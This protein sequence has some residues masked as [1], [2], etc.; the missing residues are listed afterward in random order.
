M[1]HLL[2]LSFVFFSFS[3]SAQVMGEVEIH[4]SIKVP[5]EGD[6]E[7]IT[8]FN[9]NTGKGSISQKGGEFSIAVSLHDSLYFS[10]L[11]Y[12]N[13]LV[14]VDE[15]IINTRSLHV[16]ITEDINELGEVLIRPHDLTGNLTADLKSIPVQQLDLPTWSAAEISAMDFSFAPDGQS[17]VA[18]AAMGRGTGMYGFQPKK[19]IGGLVDMIGL[20]TGSKLED[21]YRKKA[22][23]IILERE[24]TSRYDPEFFKEVLQIER[25]SIS[26]FIAFLSEQGVAHVL[27]EKEK[28]LQLLDFMIAE[29][30]QFRQN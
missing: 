19:I 15:K 5:V 9:K 7:G 18:N 3:T 22:S 1:K 28:E 30:V 29:S 12:R 27:L 24:L 25:L 16:E 6:A 10:A 26:A 13:L 8:I 23:F 4:G 2:L 20:S 14:V 11:Q 17:G 21:P